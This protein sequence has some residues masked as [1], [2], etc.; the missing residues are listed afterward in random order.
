[1]I[2]VINFIN[3]LKNQGID[4]YTGV[5][6]SLMK[7]F[8]DYINSNKEI[9][10]IVN[11]NEG[12]AIAFAAGNYLTN[13]KPC[14]V[15]LQNSGQ[16]NCI[17]PLISLTHPKVYSIPMLL[18]IGWRGEP[19][20]KDEPQHMK[21]G[22]I[23]E[24][25][26]QLC[27]IPFE[28]LDIENWKSQ[29]EKANNFMIENKSPFAILVKKNTFEKT[30]IVKKENNFNLVRENVLKK[31]IQNTNDDQIIFSTT[32]KISREIYEVRKELNKESDLDFYNVGAMGHVSQIALGASFKT[33]KKILCIDGD[34]SLIMHMGTLATIGSYQPNSFGL[35]DF[36]GNVAVWT[37]DKYQ[38]KFS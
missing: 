23:T 1:M 36:S 31:I 25:L 35:F 33:N 30:N 6:D 18:L 9:N 5:P 10:N 37:A 21:Q 11:H 29:I 22:E 19:E 13:K 12:G 14:L 2:N 15:Y 8:C 38:K 24:E 32:G 34:G 3:F 28:I 16:G 4:Y 17:N 26:L 7:N 20:I 27:D